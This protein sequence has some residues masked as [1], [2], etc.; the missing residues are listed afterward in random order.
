MKL[1][2]LIYALLSFTVGLGISTGFEVNAI[3]SVAGAA[4]GLLLYNTIKERS[5]GK[6]AF[7]S[8]LPSGDFSC[9]D[10]VSIYARATERWSDAAFSRD[11]M[12]KVQS[13]LWFLQTQ[14]GRIRMDEL[15]GSKDFDMR[16]YWPNACEIEVTDCGNDCV[17]QLTE[18]SAG[19]KDYALT[20]CKQTGF[21]VKRKDLRDNYLNWED[22]VT[23]GVIEAMRQLDQFWNQNFIAAIDGAAGVNI[24]TT[25]TDSGQGYAIPSPLWNMGIMPYFAMIQE[26]NKFS[27]GSALITGSNLWMADMNAA[28]NAG[29]ADGKGDAARSNVL[30][31]VKDLFNVDSV[32]GEKSTFLFSPGA[33][34]LVTKAYYDYTPEENKQDTRYK[35]DSFSLPGVAYDVIYK[36][37]CLDNEIYDS[38]LFQTKGDVLINPTGCNPDNVGIL[39]FI[40]ANS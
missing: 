15:K 10:L 38:W 13:L 14:Q 17:P 25:Y 19:C 8:A 4:V 35:M 5:G 27:A 24:D 1:K 18:L 31:L 32:T 12:T 21:T 20:T 26:L 39:K 37:Y 30:P 6:Y 40:C 2:F 36:N 34:A 33:A 7:Y 22:L 29:N 16:L 9:S 11:Y 28:L 23:L 3:A